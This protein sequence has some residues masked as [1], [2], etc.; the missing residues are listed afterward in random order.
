[1]NEMLTYAIILGL[2]HSS[3]H[4]VHDNAEKNKVL[5]YQLKWVLQEFLIQEV[6]LRM[7][8]KDAKYMA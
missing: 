8:W 2:T 3:V 1:V 5:G 7:Y 6:L 4:T